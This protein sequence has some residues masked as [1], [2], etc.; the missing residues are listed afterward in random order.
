MCLVKKIRSGELPNMTRLEVISK[1]RKHIKIHEDW[2][3]IV[4]KYP[5]YGPT[6]GD[7]EHHEMAIKVYENAIYYMEASK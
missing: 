6:V 5:T 3:K 7:K 4:E 1:M 2:I